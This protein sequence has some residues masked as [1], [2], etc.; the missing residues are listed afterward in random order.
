MKNT[1]TYFR[2]EFQELLLCYVESPPT[3]LRRLNVGKGH[4]RVGLGGLGHMA[5]KGSSLV[6]V[7]MLKP[8]A[9]ERGRC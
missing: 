6:Q 2:N 4:K 8:F 1:L 5:V 7:T 3:P 9:I